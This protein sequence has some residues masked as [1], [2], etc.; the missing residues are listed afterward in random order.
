MLIYEYVDIYF[1]VAFH[2]E[3][4]S[5]ID[6]LKFAHIRLTWN[7]HYLRISTRFWNSTQ[8]ITFEK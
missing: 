3:L 1:A 6:I 4:Y 8:K 5:V 2:Q 7:V